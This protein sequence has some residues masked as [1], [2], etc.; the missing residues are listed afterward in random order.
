LEKERLLYKEFDTL[1]GALSWARH[2]NDGGRTAL[3]IEGDDG[4]IMSKQDIAAAL[5][6]P[7]AEAGRSGGPAR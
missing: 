4:T 7:E 3:S 6:H 5:H 1:D 2:V